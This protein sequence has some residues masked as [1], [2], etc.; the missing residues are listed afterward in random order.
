MQAL[1]GKLKALGRQSDATNTVA[2]F[3]RSNEAMDDIWGAIDKAEKEV[4]LLTYI[5]KDDD[6]GRETMR[7]LEAAA[8]RG[9]KVLFLYDD[10]GN[11]TKRTRLTAG[12]A[13]AG[14]EVHCFRPCWG[15][16]LE[17]IASGFDFLKSPALRNHRKL[18]LI[19]GR[20]GYCGGLN[21]GNEYA[22]RACTGPYVTS[23][24]TFRDVMVRVEGPVLAD[25]RALIDDT[26]RHTR[27]DDRA[28]RPSW[29]DWVGE[30]AAFNSACPAPPV[31][32]ALLPPPTCSHPLGGEE[33]WSCSARPTAPQPAQPDEVHGVACQMLACHP[34][35]RDYGIQKSLHLVASRCKERLWI[36]TPYYA[37]P[38]HVRDAIEGAAER[39]V[40][41]RIIVGG[42]GTTDPP[43]M[44]HVQLEWLPRAIGRG[45]KFY[46]YAKT[47]EIMHAKLWAADGAVS[48]LG[49]FNLDLLS[50]RILEANLCVNSAA[51]TQLIEKQFLHDFALSRP[52]SGDAVMERYASASGFAACKASLGIYHFARWLLGGDYSMARHL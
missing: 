34:W 52:L 16:T 42:P 5:A 32:T 1:W 31:D 19:D 4:L 48:S 46:E 38:D 30:V 2:I 10:A 20:V 36:T 45:V 49:S 24:K 50:D 6:V 3:H 51:A 28:A 40:D 33:G 17:Y 11:I 21:I 18:I 7:H 15:T 9:V 47:G 26:F 13:G 29:A 22:G 23:G 14:G 37:P 8:R 41:V 35:D 43:I 39:G 27:P 44:R 12:L 25:I